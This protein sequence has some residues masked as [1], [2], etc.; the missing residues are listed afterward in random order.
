MNCEAR[1]G[2]FVADYRRKG[3]LDTLLSIMKYNG[4]KIRN[5]EIRSILEVRIALD[6]LVAQLC[7]DRITEEEIQLLEIR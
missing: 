2:T 1:V 4:G 7:I 6:T 3:T 5:E